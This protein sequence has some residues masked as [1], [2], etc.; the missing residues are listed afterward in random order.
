[1]ATQGKGQKLGPAL[2]ISTLIVMLLASYILPYTEFNE[3]TIDDNY[4]IKLVA[5]DLGGPSCLEWVNSSILIICDRDGGRLISLEFDYNTT[6]WSWNVSQHSTW[7]DGFDRPHGVHIAA[8]FIMVSEAGRLTRINHSGLD[9]DWMK[10]VKQNERWAM[11]DGISI[12]NHQPNAINELV[13]G[14]LVW[15]VGST[16]NVCDQD[17]ERNA[18]LLWVNA[19]TGEHGVLASGVRNSYDGVW[20]EGIGY[21]FSDNGRDWEG[22]HPLEEV[23]LLVA[24]ADYG[25]PEDD[26]DHPI[27]TGTIGPVATWTA[28][29]S[30][31]GMTKRPMN[32]TFPGNEHT[33]YATVFGSWNAVV[34]V[35][36]EIV[37]IDFEENSTNPQGW[38]GEVTTFASNLTT[39][40]PI[41]FHPS[42]NYLFYGILTGGGTLHLITAND[43]LGN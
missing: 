36:H 16:C 15:H 11:I 33:V 30:L 35:G 21:L 17:D 22:K 13:N 28:H 10:E 29:S 41:A 5:E 23:N 12:G 42:G 26:P 7:L 32:S 40:L 25:W 19:S 38:Q 18:A 8:G 3:P 6:D 39:P 27:P 31:N 9:T 20:V 43:N 34:P 37:Q 14:T 2:L 1:M 24:G 4:T